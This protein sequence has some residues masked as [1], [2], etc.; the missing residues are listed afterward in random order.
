[1]RPTNSGFGFGPK[2]NNGNWR[3]DG[4]PIKPGSGPDRMPGPADTFAA[5]GLAWA[6]TSNTPLRD[7]KQS[8]YEGGIR[9][10]LIARWPA[11][12]KQAGKL[13]SEVGHVIDIMAT[14]LDAAGS[15]Y[16]TEFQG[17][18]PLPLEGKSLTP[19]FRGQ[20][21]MPHELLAWKCGRGRAIRS[22]PWKLVR[23]ADNRP[24]ELYNLDDDP[25]ETNNLAPAAPDRVALL[26]Q[27]YQ[28][29]RTRVGAK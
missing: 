27:Q 9:T 3:K 23:P 7:T 1:L 15:E 25:G 11:V 4:V 10:P 28:A 16:P 21:R 17:R 13:T 22:G 20:Q 29:W 12:I 5:Y 8:A 26:T 2:S 24:W 14:I 19:V 18:R 6:T